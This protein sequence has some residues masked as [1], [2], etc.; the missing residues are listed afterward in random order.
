MK[1]LKMILSDFR[2]SLGAN[3]VLLFVMTAVIFLFLYTYGQ[4]RF[5]IQNYNILRKNLSNF[6]YFEDYV[7]DFRGE[8]AYKETMEVVN[9]INQFEAVK[10]AY[11]YLGA[12]GFLGD[13]RCNVSVY[14]EDIRKLCP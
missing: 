7:I 12:A 2:E 5:S 11:Y 4:Y 1:R 8:E 14:N 6:V 3:L 9:Q 10:T 13:L